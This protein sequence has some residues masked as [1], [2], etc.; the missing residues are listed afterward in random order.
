MTLGHLFLVFMIIAFHIKFRL[1]DL[2]IS[3][4]FSNFVS[5]LFQSAPNL[6]CMFIAIRRSAE[7][8]AITH[9]WVLLELISLCFAC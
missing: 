6:V 8:K 5:S 9:H 3:L 4:F 1:K 2:H 7:L